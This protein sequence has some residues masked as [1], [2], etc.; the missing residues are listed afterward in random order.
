ME[1]NGQ[2]SGFTKWL[3]GTTSTKTRSQGFGTARPGQTTQRACLDALAG[4]AHNLHIYYYLN[5]DVPQ[6]IRV[7]DS[8]LRRGYLGIRSA[9]I[10]IDIVDILANMRRYGHRVTEINEILWRYLVELLQIQNSDGGF[11][12]TYT[13][14]H[15]L[16]GHKT[17]RR[18][19][20]MWTTWFRLAS[21][22]M[23]ANG[24]VKDASLS[25]NLGRRRR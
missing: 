16:Y 2:P 22:G 12:D 8:C 24:F 10:D 14:P 17:P 9:C 15:V 4:A 19:S 7:V 18:R 23:A 25:W 21:I 11:A 13:T 6:A 5:R 1:P 20:I 3:I